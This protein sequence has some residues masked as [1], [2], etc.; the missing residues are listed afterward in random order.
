MV[1][2]RII[3]S[4]VVLLTEY[5]LHHRLEGI[6]LP[7]LPVAI[8]VHLARMLPYSPPRL[9]TRERRSIFRGAV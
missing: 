8:L 1:K 5:L 9:D 2:D 6:Q 4:I 3:R 7:G